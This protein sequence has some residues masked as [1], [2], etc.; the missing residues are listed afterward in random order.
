MIVSDL[1]YSDD[2]DF[3]ANYEIY[4]CTEDGKQY[5]DGAERIFC[6]RTDGY[7][8]MSAILDMKVKYLTINENTLIIEAT[9]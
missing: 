2:M 6:S 3:N 4:D 8:P 9:A 7:K 5:G 1:V